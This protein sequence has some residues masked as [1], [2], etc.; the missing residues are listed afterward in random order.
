[1]CCGSSDDYER[2]NPQPYHPQRQPVGPQHRAMEQGN[3][4]LRAQMAATRAA[5]KYGWPTDRQSHPQAGQRGQA[6]AACRDS[7]IEPGLAAHLSTMP[8]AEFRSVYD[9]QRA[10]QPHPSSGALRRP[11][12][13]QMS[14]RSPIQPP[15]Y[16]QRQQQ[17]VYQQPA[18]VKPMSSGLHRSKPTSRPSPVSRP[19]QQDPRR[20]PQVKHAG[21]I[22]QPQS[23]VVE[24]A[25]PSPKPQY[26]MPPVAKP[27]YVTP[28]QAYAAPQM[29]YAQPYDHVPHRKDVRRDS[30][31]VSECSDEDV[32]GDWRDHCVSPTLS[33]LQDL[34]GKMGMGYGRHGAF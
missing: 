9:P 19:S 28:Q 23:A 30:N 31:G 6:T 4:K 18:A 1:M 25:M 33:P 21:R 15:Y 13:P 16:Q 12:P 27:R 34:Y 8:G 20:T 2:P 5:G 3:G 10:R 24:M 26:Q 32:G 7:F 29:G 14:Q 11:A 17:L 22:A